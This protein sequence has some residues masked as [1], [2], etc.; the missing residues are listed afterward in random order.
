VTY[1]EKLAAIR[2]RLEEMNSRVEAMGDPVFLGATPGDDR[3]EPYFGDLVTFLLTTWLPMAELEAECG[4]TESLLFT[5]AIW[6]AAAL[7]LE[8]G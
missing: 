5:Q 4:V 7:G 8:E 2:E 6:L 3:A 1:A